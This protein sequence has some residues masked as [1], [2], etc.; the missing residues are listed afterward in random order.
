[1]GLPHQEFTWGKNLLDPG[2]RPFAFY[3][4][5]D[6]F[7]FITPQGPL[8]FDNVARKVIQKGPAVPPSQLELGKAYMQYSFG[9]FLRK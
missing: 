8:T 7:G 5:N 4:F 3:V 6:G 2:T 9:D 1:M